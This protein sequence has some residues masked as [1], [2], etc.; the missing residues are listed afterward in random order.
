[1][2]EVQ[3]TLAV[4]YKGWNDYQSALLKVLAPLT[5]EQ[6]M[7]RVAPNE[8][9]IGEMATHII[10]ARAGWFYELMGEGGE[11]FADMRTWDEPGTPARSSAAELISGLETSWRIMHEAMARWTPA[12]WEHI[13]KGERNGESYEIPRKWVIW[14]LIEH[15]LHHGGE[16]SLTLGMHGLVAPDI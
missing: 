12:E 11:L 4:F 14:H 7:L 3:S 9:T 16:I 1:M 15:D 10:G 2:S 6:L 5:D 8:R 13:Y